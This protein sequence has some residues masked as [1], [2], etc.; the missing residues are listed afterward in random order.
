M[1]VRAV[2]CMT[3]AFALPQSPV[4][5]P[6]GPASDAHRCRV[7]LQRVG[8]MKDV[9]SNALTLGLAQPEVRVKEFLER[10]RVDCAD[11]DE[12]LRRSAAGF[13]LD[14]A[15]LTA[16]VE[17]FRHI[18]CVSELWTPETALTTFAAD[19]TLHVVLHELGHALIREF[20]LPVLANEETMADAFAT[21]YLTAHLPERAPAVLLAR[22]ESLLVEAAE[23]PRADWEVDGEHDNDARRAH[24]IAALAVAADPER[25]RAVGQAVGMDAD[26]LRESRDWGSEVHR[27]WRR[28]L[29]PLWMPEG[30]ASSEAR[31]QV[32]LGG[33][34]A[35]ELRD[36][37][38]LVELEHALRRFDW[39]SQVT[40]R[41][42]P[43]EGTAGWSRSARAITV[44]EAYLERF[45]A[46]GRTLAR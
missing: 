38:L 8:Q 23:V 2:A 34:R 42:L 29:A 11:G 19:V 30:L 17:R 45:V 21:C 24:Q 4:V 40:L 1:S 41:F 7:D 36:S 3:L 10:T 6:L 35:D 27:A 28:A 5:D 32:E 26:A 16:E 12:L 14:V 18:N 9:L 39:H 13:E 43:G 37:G 46:Q 33:I 22:V 25:Y 31:L 15:A 44:R 20:D